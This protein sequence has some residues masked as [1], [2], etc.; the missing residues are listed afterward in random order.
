MFSGLALLLLLLL[1]LLLLLLF[2]FFDIFLYHSL[3]SFSSLLLFSSCGFVGLV[4]HWILSGIIWNFLRFFRLFFSLFL[5]AHR[6]WK[7][8]RGGNHPFVLL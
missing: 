5:F 6:L 3:C 8:G 2:V 7:V 4:S 1:I